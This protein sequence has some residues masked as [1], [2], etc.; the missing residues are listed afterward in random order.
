M[1]EMFGG[2]EGYDFE[3]IDIKDS[4]E[5]LEPLNDYT[6]IRTSEMEY[7]CIVAEV[8]SNAERVKSLAKGLMTAGDTRLYVK[9]KS[10]DNNHYIALHKVE[11][12]PR[13]VNNLIRIALKDTVMYGRSEEDGL[14]MVTPE[15][16]VRKIDITLGDSSD[17]WSKLVALESTEQAADPFAEFE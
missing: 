14:R 9:L 7:P 1:E 2:L 4:L 15:Q 17:Y 6:M 3:D 16:F 10:D 8:T 5:T 13:N 11:V 12:S